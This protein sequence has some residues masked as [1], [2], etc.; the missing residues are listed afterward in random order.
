MP[1]QPRRN[2]G[3]GRLCG[4]LALLLLAG[5]LALAQSTPAAF[6]LTWQHLQEVA[7]PSTGFAVQRC[8]QS[9]GSC[10]FSDLAGATNIPYT[11]PTWTDSAIQTNLQFC[12]KVASVNQFG[13]SP[14][15]STFCATLGGP[16]TTAPTSLNIR[17]VPATP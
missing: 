5:S 13:R 2:P 16:P 10:V 6:V 17:I 8:L 1:K 11:S 4:A 14:Y 15:S 7:T 12:Y 9:G 3:L